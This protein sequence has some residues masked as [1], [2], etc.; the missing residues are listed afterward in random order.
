MGNKPVYR[1]P[2]RS[3]A[4]S[5]RCDR[6]LPFR[7]GSSSAGGGGFWIVVILMV[8]Y[9]LPAGIFHSGPA[10]VIAGAIW[11]P[12]LTV[13][14]VLCLYG[15]YKQKHPGPPGSTRTCRPP[16]GRLPV[17]AT[18][19]PPVKDAPPGPLPP[20]PA[21]PP[22]AVP[23][24]MARRARERDLRARLRATDDYIARIDAAL[25]EETLDRLEDQ[26]DRGWPS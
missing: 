22:A 3:H 6:C 16:R 15:S 13:F 5:C 11:W 20:P 24:D 12:V 1:Y 10:F 17:E 4:A 19:P 7:S 25:S 8:L 26:R 23:P 2:P 18:A 14:T 21:P 9:G